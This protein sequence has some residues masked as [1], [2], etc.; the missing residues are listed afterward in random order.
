MS[1]ETS[2]MA[3][4]RSRGAYEVVVDQTNYPCTKKRIKWCIAEAKNETKPG[5]AHDIALLM[6]LLRVDD[7][8]YP[9]S[10]PVA[11]L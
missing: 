7:S 6:H 8:Y 11:M 1:G 5:Q 9:Q 2:V 10:N 4:F 3:R